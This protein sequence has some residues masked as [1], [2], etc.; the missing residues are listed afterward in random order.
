MVH[1]YKMIC[2]SKNL[3]IERELGSGTASGINYYPDSSRATFLEV[4]NSWNRL[5]LIQAKMM[6]KKV[7]Y[8]YI[9]L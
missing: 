8:I 4:I 3:E 2:L 1:K 9:A 6:R 7:D 5:A